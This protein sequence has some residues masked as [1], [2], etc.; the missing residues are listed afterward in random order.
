[1]LGRFSFVCVR[2]PSSNSSKSS[3]LFSLCLILKSGI[4]LQDTFEFY[5][6][7][8]KRLLFSMEYTHCRLFNWKPI[9]V[10]SIYFMNKLLVSLIVDVL[11]QIMW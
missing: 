9:F 2:S 11:L 6:A 4:F 10:L 1:M 8:G 7:I 3:Q 5:F